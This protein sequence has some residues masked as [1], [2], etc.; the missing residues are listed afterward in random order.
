MK[1]III[2]YLLFST[3]AFDEV[4]H[5]A[6]ASSMKFPLKDII[7]EF[8][9][10]YKEVDI[11]VSFDS[12]GNLTAKILRG[13][14]YDLFISAGKIY[15]SKLLSA[16]NNAYMYS[17]AKGKLALISRTKIDCNNVIDVL[18]KSEILA[19]PNPTHAP[20]GSAGMG[21]LKNIKLYD[22]LKDKLVYGANALH[23]AHFVKTGNADLG[24][25]S[26]SV[27]LKSNL[28]FCVI[29]EGYEKP[30]YF[31]VVLNNK[32]SVKNFIEFLKSPTVKRIL[33]EY[34]IYS[35]GMEVF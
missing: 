17:L 25:T 15:A 12:S 33:E 9:R 24:I 28:N 20:Y 2:I 19:I 30:E 22:E 35:G 21:F 26:L 6:S 14:K 18:K 27:A 31:V 29:E 23:V 16:K 4:I 13:A 34:G 7:M 3:A 5:I 1:I 10:E 11:K 32:R 8:K